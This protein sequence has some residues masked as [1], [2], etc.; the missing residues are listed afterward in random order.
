MQWSM[1]IYFPGTIT[2]FYWVRVLIKWL[3]EDENDVKPELNP[4]KRL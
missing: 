2:P 4:V 1:F 3:D